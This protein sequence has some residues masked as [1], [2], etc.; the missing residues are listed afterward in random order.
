MTPPFPRGVRDPLDADHNDR[1]AAG[2]LAGS[3][4]DE[5]KKLCEVTKMALDE[6]IK[7]CKPGVAY[8][9][10]GGVINDIADAHKLGVIREYVG[11]GV[12]R[13]FHSAPTITHNRNNGPGFMKAGQ[14]FTI[15]PMLVQVG[16]HVRTQGRCTTDMQ[17]AQ[18][19]GL[20]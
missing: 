4:S 11:H 18:G 8:R 9:Q 16:A 2:L 13:A 12:G 6:A 15:E 1:S 17:T 19:Y 20:E 3:V 5:A 7:I 14:T 10:I